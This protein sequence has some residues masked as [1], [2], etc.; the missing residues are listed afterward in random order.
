VSRLN[1]D[2]EIWIREQ[3]KCEFT[4]RKF[5]TLWEFRGKKTSAFL[6]N[7]DIE[8]AEGIVSVSLFSF[9]YTNT[10]YNELDGLTELTSSL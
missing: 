7:R 8:F 9:A 6:G 5:G 4:E 2:T 1:L 3:W 10:K